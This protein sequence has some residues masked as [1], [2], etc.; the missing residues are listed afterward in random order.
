MPN[1]VVFPGGLCEPAD[2][3][4][5]WLAIA[6]SLK[7]FTVSSQASFPDIFHNDSPMPL[8]VSS[9]LNDTRHSEQVQNESGYDVT[10]PSYT[11]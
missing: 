8:Q 3:S 11:L 6:P 9:E 5:N 2:F 10:I 7:N 4:L 1:N